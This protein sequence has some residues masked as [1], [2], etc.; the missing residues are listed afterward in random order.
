MVSTC[1]GGQW[2]RDAASQ[3]K[4][5]EPF[6]SEIRNIL[7]TVPVS[8]CLRTLSARAASCCANGLE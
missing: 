1:S 8:E 5:L 6:D 4:G 7:W 3:K 2:A